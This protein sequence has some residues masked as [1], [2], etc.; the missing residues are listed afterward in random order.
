MPRFLQTPIIVAIA[1]FPL[2]AIADCKDLISMSKTVSSSTQSRSSFESSAATFC[3]EYKK[4]T[5]I[6]KSANYGISYKLIAASMGTSKAS[7]EEVASKVCSANAGE[8]SRA[9]AY[10]QYVETI[11][12]NAYKAYEACEKLQ[13][14]KIDISV[15][16]ILNDEVTISV[17]NS[18]TKA[19]PATFQFITSAGATCQW[20]TAGVAPTNPTSVPPGT[21]VFLKC[22]RSNIGKQESITIGDTSDGAGAKLTIPWQAV[23]PQ[24]IGIDLVGQLMKRVEEAISVSKETANSLSNGVVAFSATACPDGW[25]AYTPAF[26]RFIRGIDQSNSAIDPSGLRTLGSIQNDSV[27]K[28]AHPIT[29]PGRAGNKAFVNK[30]P[31]WG[32]DDWQGAASTAQ[33]ETSG[34]DETRPKN[35]ALLYCKKG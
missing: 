3:S 10:Q 23:T 31:G 9:D 13:V 11:S 32:Y 5:T 2:T 19:A 1:M 6:T 8:S 18:S 14:A 4:G 27:G 35:V 26:G 33:T 28:H 34:D 25:S 30:P 24:G 29:L 7:E 21:T 20:Q 16:S 17:G 12:D 15:R 22:S